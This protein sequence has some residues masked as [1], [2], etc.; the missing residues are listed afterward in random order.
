MKRS[1]LN[2]IGKVGKANIAANKIIKCIVEDEQIFFCEIGLK[3]CLRGLYLQ[4]A[5]R[6]KRAYYKGD[7]AK[8]ADYNEWVIACQNCHATTEWD[9]KLNEE[10]FE[11]LR[12]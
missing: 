2:K 7:V 1:P 4:I 11:R 6:H 3:G 5:H 9:R 12:P 10:V 8:L